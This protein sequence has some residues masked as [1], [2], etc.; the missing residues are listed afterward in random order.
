MYVTVI[1]YLG[2]S[3]TLSVYRLGKLVRLLELQKLLELLYSCSLKQSIQRR[4]LFKLHGDA[5]VKNVLRLVK[6][7]MAILM[8][9]YVT[10]AVYFFI[11]SQVCMHILLIYAIV[12]S[13]Y[14]YIHSSTSYSFMM[15][16]RTGLM[17]LE[18]YPIVLHTALRTTP[19]RLV[20]LYQ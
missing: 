6:L 13:N 8:I 1:D 4:T 3:Q 19:I 15:T 18:F 2:P 16:Q 7:T 17:L 20:M 5:S 11:A 12:G 14:A 10:G 9:A